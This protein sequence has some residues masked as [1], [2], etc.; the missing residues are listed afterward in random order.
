[1]TKDRTR[2]AKSTPPVAGDWVADFPEDPAHYAVMIGDVRVRIRRADRF[3]DA[4]A[5][6]RAYGTR[7]ADYRATVQGRR[8]DRRDG[9][10]V[11]DSQTPGSYDLVP[12]AGTRRTVH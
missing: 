11:W 7:W 3:F 9:Q 1:M 5:V 6:A 2:R 8:G 10:E 4:S 12:V